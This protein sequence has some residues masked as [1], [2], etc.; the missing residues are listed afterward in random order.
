MK[1]KTSKAIDLFRSGQ[2]KE[3]FALFRTFRLGFTECERR[4]LQIAHETLCGHARFYAEL[5]ID[6]ATAVEE[7]KLIIIKKYNQ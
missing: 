4:T 5:G 7:S 3:A 1:T 6:P 2:L